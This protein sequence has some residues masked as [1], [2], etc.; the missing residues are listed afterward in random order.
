M[1]FQ[2]FSAQINLQLAA[3]SLIRNEPQL[4]NKIKVLYFYPQ[5][6][7]F[8]ISCRC[9]KPNKSETNKNAERKINQ[10]NMKQLL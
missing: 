8:N 9:L 6:C 7:F 5:T 2:G 10:Q 4:H 3:C 1:P